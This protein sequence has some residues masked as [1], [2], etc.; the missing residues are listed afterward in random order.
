MWRIVNGFFISCKRK[1]STAEWLRINMKNPKDQRFM[2]I[3][4]KNTVRMK[5]AILNEDEITCVFINDGRVDFR[6]YKLNF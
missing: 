2:I 4:E 6:V 1:A 5:H 3:A